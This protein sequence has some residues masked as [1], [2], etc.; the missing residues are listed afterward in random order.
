M[1]F[2]WEISTVID[3]AL[4][5]LLPF[6][7]ILNAGLLGMGEP[8]SFSYSEAIIISLFFGVILVFQNLLS[9]WLKEGR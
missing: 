7:L 8:G 4:V 9:L 3:L 5:R 1:E 6:P 2:K